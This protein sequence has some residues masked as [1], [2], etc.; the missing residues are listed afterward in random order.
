VSAA[1]AVLPLLGIIGGAPSSDPAVVCL[2]ADTLP[3]CSGTVVSTHAVLTAGHCA[4]TLGTSVPYFIAF[5]SD[6]HAPQRRARITAFEVHPRYSGEGKPFDLALARFDPPLVVA[7][8]PV[9][10]EGLDAGAPLRH[11]GY[12]TSNEL[13]MS[14]W[15]T[16]RAVT[17]PL[18]RLDDDFL[19][20][21][22]PAANT[23]YGDSGGPALT[24]GQLVAVVSDGPDCH[25]ESRDA[26]VDLTWLDSVLAQW[27][28]PTSPPVKGCG[29]SSVEATLLAGAAL[30]VTSS[31]R[32]RRFPK[33][34]GRITRMRGAQW[35][36]SLL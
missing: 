34:P 29:C 20:S 15:G 27:D 13:E 16:Q 36:S 21:G 30:I 12:G 11:V 6:C 35:T 24:A 22:D 5:G 32:K 7:P 2:Q 17:H 25:S 10:R 9:T 1:L 18:N 3:I 4:N 8:V 26:R 33:S 31:R 14:G 19:Y 28:P 23:C